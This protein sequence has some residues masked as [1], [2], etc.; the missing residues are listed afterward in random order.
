MPRGVG[1]SAVQQSRSDRRA[2][3]SGTAFGGVTGTGIPDR[4][5]SESGP[6]Q[7]PDP[8]S[9][10]WI[11]CGLAATSPRNFLVDAAF[12]DEGQE[13]DDPAQ[14]DEDELAE[15]PA[16]Q[17][18]EPEVG[19]Q[20]DHVHPAMDNQHRGGDVEAA[21]DAV[22]AVLDGGEA[23]AVCGAGGRSRY[24]RPS[25]PNRRRTGPPVRRTA[26]TAWNRSGTP[27]PC[28]SRRGADLRH[29]PAETAFGLPGRFCHFVTSLDGRGA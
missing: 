5:A 4:V 20:V 24:R 2:G 9:T 22:A 3:S 10:A 14:G 6:P 26:A 13:R 11:A 21:G 12:H 23:E 29:R 1:A 19:D 18:P 8:T 15:R 17:R 27:S 7:W 16:H 28:R 25:A